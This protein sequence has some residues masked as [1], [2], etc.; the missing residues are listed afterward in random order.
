MVENELQTLRE[1]AAFQKA[2]YK[3]QR[4]EILSFSKYLFNN[5]ERK[6]S[7]ILFRCS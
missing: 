6:S 7:F 4:E 2:N 3:A 5:T 1:H